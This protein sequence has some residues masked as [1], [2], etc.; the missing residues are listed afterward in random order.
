MVAELYF[1]PPCGTIQPNL[2]LRFN[3]QKPW[4]RPLALAFEKPRPGHRPSEAI[5]MAWLGLA[6][7]GPAWPG[8][9]LQAR[10]GTSLLQV[11][12]LSY[13]S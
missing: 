11:L 1:P 8:F 6:F 10:A 9:W 2:N 7:F 4:L 12:I 5:L 13:T 3:S